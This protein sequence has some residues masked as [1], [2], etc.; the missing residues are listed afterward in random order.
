MTYSSSQGIRYKLDLV[1]EQEVRW[2]K[3]GTVRAGD[4]KI[5]L[6]KRKQKSSVGNRIFCIPQNNISSSKSTVF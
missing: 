4:Y 3:E 2:D 6:W 1:N 5:F